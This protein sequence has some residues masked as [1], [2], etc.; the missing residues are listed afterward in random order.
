MKKKKNLRRLI[1]FLIILLIVSGLLYGGYRYF[2]YHFEIKE[3]FVEGNIHYTDEEIKNIVM[4]G[5]LGNNSFYLSMKYK[6]KDIKDVPFIE[7]MDV[8]V[9]SADSIKISVYEKALA[10]FSEYLGTYIYF[11]KDG[12][13]VEVSSVKTSGIPEVLGLEFDYA[14]LY[15]PLPVE[16]PKMFRSVLDITQLMTKY[17]VSAEKM[18]FK[19]NGEI[20][21][22]HDKVV[23]NL[24]DENNLDIKIMNLPSILDNLTGKEG[25][26]HM[27]KY[28]E[29]TKNVSF[30]PKSMESFQKEDDV[31]QNAV[32]EL[33]TDGE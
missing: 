32:D 5:F 1:S 26:L 11:D 8:S 2:C 24:G 23:I 3:A 33:L 7:K 4:D 25:V 27:E 18:Y 19:P 16:N 14:V 10:G 15:E 6:N 20:V 28:D 17:K 29:N 21:I 13:I 9:L 31:I 22:Y 12:I 30:D